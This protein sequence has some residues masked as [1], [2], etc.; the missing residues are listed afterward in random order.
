MIKVASLFSQVL[1]L[2][3]HHLFQKAC[4]EYQTERCSKGFSSW[5]QFVS[6]LFS[7]FAGANSFREIS[8]GLATIR[9]KINH[10][11]I[12]AAPKKSTLAYANAYSVVRK[13]V[14]GINSKPFEDTF[15]TPDGEV[16]RRGQS[17]HLNKDANSRKSSVFYE[18]LSWWML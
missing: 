10:L 9:G 6:L 8:G 3:D 11:G 13:A 1:S 17:L 16:K 7:Q 4:L 2:I 15:V 12:K 14:K 5:N 18:K